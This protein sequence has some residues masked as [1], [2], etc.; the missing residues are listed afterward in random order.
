MVRDK[1]THS[2]KINSSVFLYALA[3]HGT[4]AWAVGYKRAASG[5][6]HGYVLHT[7]GKGWKALKVAGSSSLFTSVSAV[8]SGAVVG[9]TYADANRHKFT[10]VARLTSTG[11]KVVASKF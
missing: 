6:I 3:M 11:G 10:V 5:T 2:V 4:S 7:T 9:G 1:W 8:G